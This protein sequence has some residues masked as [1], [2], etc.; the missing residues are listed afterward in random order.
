M[1]P[2][3]GPIRYEAFPVFPLYHCVNVVILLTACVLYLHPFDAAR[4]SMFWIALSHVVAFVSLAMVIGQV[5]LFLERGGGG[6]GPWGA[7]S[8][9]LSI[10]VLMA[11]GFVYWVFDPPAF[12][13]LASL[14]AFLGTVGFAIC[15]VLTHGLFPS[16]RPWRQSRDSHNTGTS[17][18]IS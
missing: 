11:A 1:L 14:L 18:A 4:P 10:F 13:W 6:I 12:R 7:R 8:Q 3:V 17:H 9:V 16:R 5:L 15:P 2:I